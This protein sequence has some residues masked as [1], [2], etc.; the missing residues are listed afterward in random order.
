[1]GTLNLKAIP[2]SAVPYS[3]R[4]ARRILRS[5]LRRRN[6]LHPWRW[7]L[8]SY[9]GY[10]GVAI[11]LVIDHRLVERASSGEAFV[12]SHCAALGIAESFIDPMCRDQVL[13]VARVTY[14]DNFGSSFIS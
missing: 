9:I 5:P 6:P 4:P 14:Q 7:G 1:M 12:Q 11:S 10:F 2:V 3:N 8:N 13:E